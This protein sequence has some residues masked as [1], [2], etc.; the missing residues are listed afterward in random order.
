MTPWFNTRKAAQVV[1]F[2]A[3]R[4]GGAINVLKAT[5]LVY[6]ADRLN[7]EKFDFP[8]TGDNFVSMDHGPVNSVTLSCINGMEGDRPDWESFLTDRSGH[9]VGVSNKALSEDDL[10]ELSDAEIG[11]LDE[12][13]S[14]FGHMDRY[15]VRDWTHLN[16]PEWEDP[17]GSSNPI[18]FSRVFKFLGKAHP[19]FLENQ[20]KIGRQFQAAFSST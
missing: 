7:M 19:D 14:K 1:A 18:P 2:F 20:V 15:V 8:I 12:I 9:E 11:T 6:L 10:D 16:C 3:I 17:E 5:K 4:E 13:W